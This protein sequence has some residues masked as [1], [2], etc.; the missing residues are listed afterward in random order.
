[1]E[2]LDALAAAPDVHIAV[3]MID[4]DRFKAVND[5]L[6]HPVGDA[7][8]QLVAKRLGATLR[9]ADVIA[10]FGGDEFAIAMIA[11]PDP[12]AVGKRVVEVLSRPY[13]VERTTATIGASVGIALSSLHGTEANAL[14]RAADV[15]LYAAKESGR[16]AVRLF[17]PELDRI[18]RKRH[19]LAE[20]L[21]KAIPLQQFEVHYQPQ[22]NLITRELTGFEALVRWRHPEHGMV[23][24]DTFIPLAEE[25]GFIWPLGEWV[26]RQACR[27]ASRWPEHLTV[28]VNVSPRQLLDRH[29]LNRVIESTLER[30]GLAAHRLEIEITESALVCEAEALAVLRPLREMG[31]RVSMDDFGTGYSSLSQLR[32]FSFDK[33]KIDR[34]FVRDLGAS[35]EAAA[36]IRAIAA[37]GNSLGMTT[38]AEGVETL[39][40]AAQV[41]EDGCTE[42]QGYLL[43]KPVPASRGPGHHRST[44]ANGQLQGEHLVS[45]DLF[46]IVYCSR[47]ALPPGTPVPL[48]GILAAS[49]RN[50]GAEGV[51]GALLFS[52]GNFAQVLEGDFYAVQ[53]TFERIQ[54]DERHAE[55]V[56]L[57]AQPIETRMF[58]QWEMALAS[59]TDPSAVN[60]VLRSAMLRPGDTAAVQLADL[61]NALVRRD[62]WMAA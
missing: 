47:N 14:I 10:R 27:E 19:G 8:L 11:P 56:L 16:G 53:R 41:R 29:R 23:P 30:T 51:T 44:H 3:L 32:K 26:L 43:S 1:M 57:Q 22:M 38:I 2:R 21:R 58:G 6:G 13:L 45:N 40:Q 18:A 12:E 33:L 46:R 20:D 50:N 59:P 48:D 60:Q 25:T 55:V 42:M 5:S 9:G 15:A 54:G 37:L 49:R 4:L 35:S 61:L 34:S 17:D 7:L 28:A 24:P 52:D 36:V 39:E 62:E 31:V